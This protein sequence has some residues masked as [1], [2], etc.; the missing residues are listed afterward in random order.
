MW[1]TTEESATHMSHDL[2]CSRCGHAAH[3]FLSCS[4]TCDCVPAPMPGS[5]VDQRLF[6][7]AQH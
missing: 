5:P 6:A 2:P 1:D 4:D 3:T 7:E